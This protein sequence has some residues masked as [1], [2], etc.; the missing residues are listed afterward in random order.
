[1]KTI[2]DKCDNYSQS[3]CGTSE[4]CWAKLL[5][6]SKLIAHMT[7]KYVEDRMTGEKNHC[8][9]FKA[10]PETKKAIIRNIQEHLNR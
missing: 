5:T 4:T 1:M 2:C 7:E 9:E 6:G 8:K 3:P 10:I